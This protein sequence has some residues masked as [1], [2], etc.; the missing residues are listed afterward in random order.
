MSYIL[1]EELTQQAMVDG[2]KRRP[3]VFLIAQPTVP[4]SGRLP[5][6][7]PL[8][9]HGDITV[10]IEAGDYPTFHPEECWKK[11]KSRLEKFNPDI[12]YLAWA[13]GDTLSAVMVGAVL[14]QM[15]HYS[16]QWL[17]FD[18]GYTPDKT[19]RVRTTGNYVPMMVHFF[20]GED[21]FGNTALGNPYQKPATRRIPTTSDRAKRTLRDLIGDEDSD[22][23]LL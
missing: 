5:D 9:E 11:I 14:V 13:G 6:I 20:K 16:V 4:K 8:A 21:S 7:S 19:D 3:K 17:R 12:D 23:E 10:L 15:G 2:A 22:F 18:R 1:D